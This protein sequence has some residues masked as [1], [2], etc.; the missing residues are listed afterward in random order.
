MVAAIWLPGSGNVQNVYGTCG[1]CDPNDIAGCTDS[2]ASNYNWDFGDNL[3]STIENPAH[4]YTTGGYYDVSLISSDN[5]GCADT[6]IIN[7]L[8]YIPGPVL[9]FG[10][11]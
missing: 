4:S 10:F 11:S 6:L 1:E 5:F 8:V 9:D 7:N 3:N 2:G